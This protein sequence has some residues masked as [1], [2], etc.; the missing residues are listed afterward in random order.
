M[1]TRLLH[2]EPSAR[3]YEYSV[4]LEGSTYVVELRWN[5]RARAWFLSLFDRSR[6]AIAVGRKVALGADLRGASADGR[7][8]PGRLLALDT[9]GAGRDAG[10]ADLGARV[11]LGYV[12]SGGAA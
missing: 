10:E 3:H 7:L 12:E 4:D 9:S 5:A 1:G 6:S 2:T 11:L 8:P